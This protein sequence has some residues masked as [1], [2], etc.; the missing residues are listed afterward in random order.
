MK[1]RPPPK[2][3]Q[4]QVIYRDGKPVTDR[5]PEDV[6]EI[7]LNHTQKGHPDFNPEGSTAGSAVDV[8]RHLFDLVRNEK[9]GKKH[10]GE[11]RGEQQRERAKRIS[12]PI[13]DKF[14]ELRD[15]GEKPRTLIA[16][17]AKWA[18]QQKKYSGLGIR[19]IRR[20]IGYWEKDS[21]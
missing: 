10:G 4:T 6:A 2:D 13:Y 8:T 14:N 12:K 1:N 15:S 19:Q 16:K 11:L 9:I 5:P 21:S 17:T 18:Q 3:Q 7:Y 20:Y